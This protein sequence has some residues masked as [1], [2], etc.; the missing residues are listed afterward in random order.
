MSIEIKAVITESKIFYEGMALFKYLYMPH[1]IGKLNAYNKAMVEKY[2]DGKSY[3]QHLIKTTGSTINNITDDNIDEILSLISYKEEPVLDLLSEMTCYPDILTKIIKCLIG[4]FIYNGYRRR[5]V[6]T[7][8]KFTFLRRMKVDWFADGPDSENM[9]NKFITGL[10]SIVSDISKINTY[11]IMTLMHL[12]PED[13]RSD[14][15]IYKLVGYNKSNVLHH[16]CQ[17][18]T[19][20]D[21]ILEC[22]KY[23]PC[24]KSFY[25]NNVANR[26][27]KQEYDYHNGITNWPLHWLYSKYNYSKLMS[28]SNNIQ[29][30]NKFMQASNDGKLYYNDNNYEIEYIK[31]CDVTRAV[32]FLENIRSQIECKLNTHYAERINK[33]INKII[34]EFQSDYE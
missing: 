24:N 15:L 5:I 2:T 27:N 10:A 28:K 3:I 1:E 13:K 19:D 21:D 29:F 34:N 4:V 26:E 32:E 23:I 31:K 12:F 22:M 33:K 17:N 11:D 8:S 25:H 9:M 30:L 18:S 7:L 6:R 20:M 14:I 16:K